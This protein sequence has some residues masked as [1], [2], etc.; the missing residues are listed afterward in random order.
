MLEIAYK[1]NHT[2][3]MA[4]DVASAIGQGIRSP[5]FETKNDPLRASVEYY[6][7]HEQLSVQLSQF[8][9]SEPLKVSRL[10]TENDDL[11]ILDFH[12]S[13]AAKLKVTDDRIKGATNGL[14]HGAYFAH[15]GVESYAVFPPG[16]Y[17]QQFHI[18]LD[19]KWMARFFADDIRFIIEKIGKASH[20]FMFERLNSRITVLLLSLF[21]SEYTRSFRQSFLHG[22]TLQLLSLFFEKL[23]NRGEHLQLG[24]SG[25]DNVSRL[26]ELMVY[27]DEHLGEDLNVSFLTEKIGFSESKL[28][29]LCKAVYG[30]SL[31]KEI[32]ERRMIKALDLF[33]ENSDSI[34]AVGYQL[35]YTNMSHFAAAFKK[36]HGFLPSEYLSKYPK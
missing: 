22:M 25:Y 16:F 3:V 5:R 29:T 24:V 28:Q 30:K 26:F 7:L 36:V 17:N 10:G 15:A 14:T 8:H 18:V 12:L 34:S 31:S 1:I 23:Q 4:Q 9:Q 19:K 20:F 2:D 33:E 27:V 6:R 21:K 11:L 35:G 32:T 13:G